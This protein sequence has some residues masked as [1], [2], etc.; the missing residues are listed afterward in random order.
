MHIAIV[1]PDAA[2]AHVLAFVARRRGHQVVC[3]PYVEPSLMR[4]PFSPSVNIVAVES[5]D[6]DT[7]ATLDRVRERYLDVPILVTL[8]DRSDLLTSKALQ[9]GVRDV[10]R[11]PFHPQEVILRAEM[12]AR[13]GG[14]MSIDGGLIRLGDLHVH[15]DRFSAVKNGKPLGLTKLEFRLLY[16]LVQN[17]PHLTST[18]RLLSFGWE[19]GDPSDASLLKTHISHIRRKLAVAGG[20]ELEIYSR[21][22]IGYA[23]RMAEPPALVGVAP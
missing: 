1:E 22:S 19:S 18:D 20:V 16:C 11:K 8:E 2:M 3:V 7:L 21:Q 5:L 23:I 12:L 15:L 4:L 10:V 9:H 17:Y 6:A 13:S 14:P